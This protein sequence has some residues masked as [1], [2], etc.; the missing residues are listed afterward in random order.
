[1]MAGSMVSGWLKSGGFRLP[2]VLFIA[3]LMLELVFFIYPF[4]LE[5]G[6]S[7]PFLIKL[8]LLTPVKS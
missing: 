7:R 1:M 3:P 2:D 8:L 6:K 5:V 4:W